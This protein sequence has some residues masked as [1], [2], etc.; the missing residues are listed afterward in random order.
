[1]KPILPI[2]VASFTAALTGCIGPLVPVVRPDQLSPRAQSELSRVR[3][4]H[5]AQLANLDFEVLAFVEGHSCQNKLWDQAA[6]REAAVE[7]LRTRAVQVGAN[8]LTS[9]ECGAREPTSVRTNCWELIS[10][11]AEALRVRESVARETP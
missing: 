4:Y 10:C 8:A 2:A 6:T 11:T 3:I 9:V 5:E 7:Q 1:M